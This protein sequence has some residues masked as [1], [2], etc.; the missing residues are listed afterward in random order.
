MKLRADFHIHSC[1]SPCGD[2]EMSP[3]AIV[4]RAQE[5]GLNAL[6]LADHN[7]TLNCPAFAE[8]CRRAGIHALFGTEVTT[9]EEGHVLCLFDRL[10]AAMTFG[11]DVYEHLMNIPNNPDRFGDQVHV[12]F[13]EE[14]E[15][16]PE[17]LLIGATDISIDQLGEKVH[18]LGGLFI[19]A[20]VDRLMFSI[21]QQLGFLPDEP[22][23]AIE[24]SPR[25]LGAIEGTTY[26]GYPFI[27]NSDA[28]QLEQLGRVYNEI[29]VAEFSV[30]AIRAALIADRKAICYA[31]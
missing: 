9:V 5:I 6:G 1:L 26:K 15:G 17:K 21:E 18:S 16:F 25:G 22:Y 31:K 11:A 23:D 24:I 3:S 30:A 27:T 13:D 4:A 8:H 28:H 14:I 29:E 20:H 10:D 7:C 2:L 19:P 12:N